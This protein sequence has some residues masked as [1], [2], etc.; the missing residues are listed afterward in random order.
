MRF[1]T[2]TG[3]FRAWWSLVVVLAAA[4]CVAAGSIVYTN[5]TQREADRRWCELLAS[6][7]QPGQ[8]PTTE[9]GRQIQEQIHELRDDL[10][11]ED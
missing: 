5:H 1:F 9:R 6:L 2:A 10:G 8:P 7:D 3:A 11:C 4:V